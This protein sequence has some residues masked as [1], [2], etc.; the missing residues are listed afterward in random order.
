MAVFMSGVA[1]LVEIRNLAIHVANCNICSGIEAINSQLSVEDVSVTGAF[2][3][4]VEVSGGTATIHGLT[5]SGAGSE[6][7]LIHDAT[8]TISDSIFQN[9]AAGIAVAG[10]SAAA[11]ALIER[12]KFRSNTTGLQVIN[13]GHAALARISDCVITANATGVE[14]FGGGQIITFRNNTWAGNSTDGSTPF[15]ISLK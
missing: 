9:S 7:L 12:T 3:I 8:V 4:G 1:G 5:A 14:T 2:N 10:V 11:Q 6:G 13:A 15:S